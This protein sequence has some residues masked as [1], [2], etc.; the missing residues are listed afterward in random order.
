MIL[1]LT[2]VIGVKPH[3]GE[4]GGEFPLGCM[5]CLTSGGWGFSHNA[6]HSP[7]ISVLSCIFIDT[8]M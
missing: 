7:S 4:S 3:T 2:K 8:V 6:L 5:V 1:L